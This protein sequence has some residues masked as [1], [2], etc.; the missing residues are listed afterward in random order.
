MPLNRPNKG[1]QIQNISKPKPINASDAKN[2]ANK[3]I[4][5]RNFNPDYD[6]VVKRISNAPQ[7]LRC[8]SPPGIV[9]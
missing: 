3:E 7:G 2:I 6:M 1:N 4:F 5:L 8:G 9:T